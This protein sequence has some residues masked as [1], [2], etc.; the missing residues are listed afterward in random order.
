MSN[1][2]GNK[3]PSDFMKHPYDSIFQNTESEIVARN[4]MVIL[5]RTGNTW[6]ELSF[7]EY[8]ELRTK[9]G[10]WSYKEEILFNK[11]SKYCVSEVMA[12]KFSKNW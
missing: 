1:P 2:A 4:I 7:E 10:N 5:N 6:R 9:D 11:V 3:Y 8:K 12:N